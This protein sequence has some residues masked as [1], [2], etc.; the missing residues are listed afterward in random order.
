[1][2][3]KI[4]NIFWWSFLII[5]LEIIYKIFVVGNLFTI[6]T[7]TV[8]IFSV[9]WILLISFISSLFNEKVNKIINIVLTIAIVIL[10][11]AQIVYYNFYYSI[12]SLFSLT[13][14]G[15]GQVIQFVS[16]ANLTVSEIT[17]TNADPEK[18][19]GQLN[20]FEATDFLK[21]QI[22]FM[23]HVDFLVDHLLRSKI[24]KAPENNKTMPFTKP[25]ETNKNDSEEKSETETKEE[26]S[27]SNEQQEETKTTTESKTESTN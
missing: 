26:T 15:G 5:Y 18:L 16:G 22:G 14:G 4:N 6:N 25:Q 13:A 17:K 3:N 7:L 2:K 20:L 8:L 11:L 1:M 10:T 23:R 9:P 12:F 21:F 27:T 19:A 24:E